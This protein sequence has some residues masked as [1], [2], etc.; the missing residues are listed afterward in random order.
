[1]VTAAGAAFLQEGFLRVSFAVP[2][3]ELDAGLAAAA[4]A[5]AELD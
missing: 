2:D 1:V 3:D 5:F 4:E